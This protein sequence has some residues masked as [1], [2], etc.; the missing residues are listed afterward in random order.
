MK[1]TARTADALV[2]EMFTTPKDLRHRAE[3]W[4]EALF[5]RTEVL[6]TG[7][8]TIVVSL[9][10]EGRDEVV[11][12]AERER[13]WYPYRITRVETAGEG[14]SPAPRTPHPTGRRSGSWVAAPRL[15]PRTP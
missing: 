8:H 10:P 4:F 11:V 3:Q 5:V 15:T 7:A 9:S 12:H 1:Q 6:E 2:G 13:H 14:R